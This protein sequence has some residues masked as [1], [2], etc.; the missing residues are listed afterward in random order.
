MVA[1]LNVYHGAG[2]SLLILVIPLLRL[3]SGEK[4]TGRSALIFWLEEADY[5]VILQRRGRAYF[6]ITAYHVDGDSTRRR[7]KAKYEGREA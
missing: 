4:A 3:G 5:V 7:L 6:L 2:P 1:V